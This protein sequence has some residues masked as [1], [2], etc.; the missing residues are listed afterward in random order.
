MTPRWDVFPYSDT[1]A[2]VVGEYEKITGV[3]LLVFEI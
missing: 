1:T 3:A 2:K